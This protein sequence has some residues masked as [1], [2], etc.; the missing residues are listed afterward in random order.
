MMKPL[1]VGSFRDVNLILEDAGCSMRLSVS[2]PRSKA[3]R[4]SLQARK[5][6]ADLRRPQASL[7]NLFVDRPA[8]LIYQRL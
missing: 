7:S 2:M 3:N 5:F 1:V 8:G 6:F 4:L